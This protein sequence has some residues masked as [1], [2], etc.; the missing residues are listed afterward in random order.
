MG[1]SNLKFKQTFLKACYKR[2]N[3]VNITL[4]MAMISTSA[5]P[6]T[7]PATRITL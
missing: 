1:N 4:P 7:A 5:A 6:T 2:N 3:P